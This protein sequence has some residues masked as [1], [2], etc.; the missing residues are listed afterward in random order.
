MKIAILSDIHDNVWNL[1]AAL[2]SLQSVDLMICCGDLCS[3]F[4]VSQMAKSFHG[5][6]H[7]VFGNNDGDLF[8][9]TQ[10]AQGYAH[11]NLHGAFFQGE[12][13]GLRFAANHYVDISHAL[14]AGSDF[15]VICYGHN[16]T[17]HIETIGNSLIINPGALMGYNPIIGKDIPAT[18]VVYDTDSNSVASY[19]VAPPA[20]GSG[21]A[22]QVISYPV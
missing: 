3:P 1:A 15:D 7:I 12:F 21:V 5:P 17:Y 4:I 11:V 10:Q 2:Q 22:G 16:H 9:I 19:Q 20:R 6:I 14:V 18:F 8:R 13:A